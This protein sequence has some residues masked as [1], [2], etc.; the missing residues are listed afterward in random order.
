MDDEKQ[1][2]G[3][4]PHQERSKMAASAIFRIFFV[5]SSSSHRYTAPSLFRSAYTLTTTSNAATLFSPYIP[6]NLYSPLQPRNF[7]ER[8]PLLTC[9]HIVTA[10]V[11]FRQ[12]WNE[13]GNSGEIPS[14]LDSRAFVGALTEENNSL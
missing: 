9:I 3:E 10:A 4:T 7:K 13:P 5:P 2:C 1:G 12:R 11:D 6:D 14:L 8:I